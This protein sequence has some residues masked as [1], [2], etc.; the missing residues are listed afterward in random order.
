M[1]V[2]GRD[3]FSHQKCN[4]FDEIFFHDFGS[5]LGIRITDNCDIKS[6]CNKLVVY[7]LYYEDL[8]SL[9]TIFK[10]KTVK[11]TK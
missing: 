6:Q 2:H 8:K 5:K 9:R 11:Y 7:L 10:I 3:N 1:F 4:V